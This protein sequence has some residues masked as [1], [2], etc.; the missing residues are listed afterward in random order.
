MG[1]SSGKYLAKPRSSFHQHYQVQSRLGL[2]SYASV[3]TASREVVC[4]KPS[5]ASSGGKLADDG[6][7]AVKVV[8][9]LGTEGSFRHTD[10]QRFANEVQILQRLSGATG[11]IHL[12]EVFQ[13]GGTGFIVM[14]RGT[15]TFLQGLEAKPTLTEATLAAVSRQVLRGLAAVHAL[16]V[17]HRDLKPSN[18]VWR[19]DT[20]KICDFGDAAIVTSE[21]L[22]G[23]HGTP[24]FM[25]PEVFQGLRYGTAVDV[26]SFGIILFTLLTGALPFSFSSLEGIRKESAISSELALP[27]ASA[28]AGDLA[29]RV[30]RRSPNLRPSAEDAFGHKFLAVSWR[31]EDEATTNDEYSLRPMLQAAK[32]AGVFGEE[33]HSG[34]VSTDLDSRLCGKQ[35]E[36]HGFT[37]WCS[38]TIS[39]GRAALEV[40]NGKTELEDCRSSVTSGSTHASTSSA[41]FLS[42]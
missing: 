37:S 19:H 24:A 33:L 16:S 39:A 11:V 27:L 4:A 1:C 10:K 40:T 12:I 22:L 29:R 34:A 9:L 36:H 30:L 28:S 6:S 15:S 5:I 41:R 20:L 31:G 2:G 38:R 17:V 14:N 13:E 23:E 26:W 21:G 25:A 8:D 18:L 35:V 32:A 7:V 42:Q 3:Y